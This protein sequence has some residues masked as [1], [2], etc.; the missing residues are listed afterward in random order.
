MVEITQQRPK[1]QEAHISSNAQKAKKPT[2]VR[3]EMVQKPTT[4]RPEGPK[5]HI[6]SNAQKAKKSTAAR[7]ERAEAPSPGQRPGYKVISNAP[8]KG[9]SFKIHLIKNEN[10]LR[11]VKLLPLQGVSYISLIPRA[12]P[13]ARSFCPFRAC[14]VIS[15]IQKGVQG[16]FNHKKGVQG[17]FNRT[18]RKIMRNL[19]G[20]IIK[21]TANYSRNLPICIC[22]SRKFDKKM[23]KYAKI[24]KKNTK[25]M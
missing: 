9:K 3:P 10:P 23:G 20:M 14:W 6:S 19:Y 7:P 1:S 24:M 5:A 18:G 12:L 11:Y 21:N 25:S 17:N 4:A 13:W 16:N 22:S 2:A 8:C 15:T